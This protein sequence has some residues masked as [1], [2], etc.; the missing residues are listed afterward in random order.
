MCAWMNAP[1]PKPCY[2]LLETPRLQPPPPSTTLTHPMRCK[3]IVLIVE[4]SLARL[5]IPR[6]KGCMRGLALK[7]LRIIMILRCCTTNSSVLENGDGGA[8]SLLS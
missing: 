3:M 4:T 2:L 8:E 6:Q 5:R 1:T 7:S